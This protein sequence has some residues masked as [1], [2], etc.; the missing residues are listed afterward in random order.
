MIQLSNPS[1]PA[2]ASTLLVER[3]RVSVLTAPLENQVPMSF[4]GLQARQVCV[5]QVC[6]G[7]LEGTGESWINY[8]PWAPAGR[9]A[10]LVQGV[11]PR[12]IGM[13]AAD[14]EAAL[15]QL[16]AA[17][18]PVGRQAG[19]L[20][21]MWQAL[22]GVDIALWDLAA[23]ASGVSVAEQLVSSSS[24][25][26]SSTRPAGSAGRD[27]VTNPDPNP[28]AWSSS[29]PVSRT[30][31]PAY[32]SGVGPT[33]VEA[34]CQSALEQ[35][36]TAVKAKI[37]FGPDRDREVLR[38]ARRLIGSTYRLFADANQA[39]DL[40][41]AI[42]MLPV[43]AESEVEWL[44]EPVSQDNLADLERLAEAGSPDIAT[45]EN[46][47][48]TDEFARRAMSPGVQILQPDLAK[49]GGLSVGRQVAE[50]ASVGGA[51]IA[52]HC[53]SSAVGLAAAAQLGAAY[54]MVDWLELDIR[55]NPLRTDLLAQPLALTHG[56]IQVPG[57]PGLGIEL[58]A[59][60]VNRFRTHYEEVT[61]THDR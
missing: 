2:A 60:V 23:K 20:G 17:L 10:A 19:A 24:V 1:E 33:D 21:A 13:N 35:G 39:W 59:A 15:E 56:A 14:P 30:A 40:S 46:V 61:G 12:L 31:V 8:P 45:G 26:S 48:G 9:M 29:D 16:C 18:L 7:G 52:P 34:C 41:T 38:T 49:S 5:V 50:R 53:Y 58:D 55:D 6:A 44:E 25:S 47:Y 11:A 51:V 54:P 32:G 43:L 28:D 37:G 27:G 42:S 4:G 36:L 57:G 22:S 3:V